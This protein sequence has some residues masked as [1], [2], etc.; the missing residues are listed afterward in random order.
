VAER[1]EKMRLEEAV[2]RIRREIKDPELQML[3]IQGV[4][5]DKGPNSV[6]PKTLEDVGMN[7][8]GVKKVVGFELTLY[9]L[10]RYLVAA[11]FLVIGGFLTVLFLHH[12]PFV[13]VICGMMTVGG[14]IVAL[15][16]AK[17][18]SALRR[19]K[20]DLSRT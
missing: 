19:S 16:R 3:A 4:M 15:L 20:G 1:E 18:Y 5:S 10:G 11:C 6:I 9:I 14:T 7:P 13:G 8:E 12:F 2:S 17:K